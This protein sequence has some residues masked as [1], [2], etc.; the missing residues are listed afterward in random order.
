MDIEFIALDVGKTLLDYKIWDRL[1]K[2]TGAIEAFKTHWKTYHG[3]NQ[4]NEWFHAD[5]KLLKGVEVRKVEHMLP[6]R[7][8]LGV[9]EF[10]DYIHN[11]TDPLSEE[12]RPLIGIISGGIDLIANRVA[13]DL[14]LD[15]VE[16]NN[17]GVKDGYFTGNGRVNV[18]LLN[19]GEIIG[20]Y[21]SELGI[22]PEK[23]AYIGNGKNDISAWEA[24]GLKIGVNASKDL[25]RYLTVNALD[26][27]TVLDWVKHWMGDGNLEISP[28]RASEL[29]TPC[30][31]SPV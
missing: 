15:F 30:F 24:V 5:C 4:F 21:L 26:F 3:K 13:V 1:G 16:A 31:S 23:A 11:L 18:D 14:G 7:Y 29:G 19:K 10:M 22:P 9:K 2:A 12:E 8:T 27:Y 28:K 20:Q 17:V 25:Q 6:L